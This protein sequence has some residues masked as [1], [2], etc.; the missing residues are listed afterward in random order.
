MD[1]DWDLGVSQKLGQ[2]LLD[3]QS[4][5][6]HAPIEKYIYQLLKFIDGASGLRFP[7]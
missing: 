6:Y 5:S 7:F 1:V 3:Q 4:V 2:S